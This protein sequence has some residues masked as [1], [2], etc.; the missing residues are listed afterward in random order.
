MQ[1]A[2]C[3]PGCRVAPAAGRGSRPAAG[4]VLAGG[5]QDAALGGDHSA[6]GG[7]QKYGLVR[8]FWGRQ[9]TWCDSSSPN[10]GAAAVQPAPGYYSGCPQ[11][12]PGPAG[13][14][15][16]VQQGPT[17]SSVVAPEQPV[18]P[19]DHGGSIVS[20]PHAAPATASE[21]IATQLSDS[22]SLFSVTKQTWKGAV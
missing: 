8:I 5:P 2:V 11:A 17:P 15:I 3:S 13:H 4:I 14:R 22:V 19:V 12:P 9:N 7:Y 21:T 6:V 10:T 20:P 18:A 1:Q 16:L